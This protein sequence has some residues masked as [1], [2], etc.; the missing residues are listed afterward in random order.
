MICS[1]WD[2][3]Q[4]QRLLEFASSHKF[5][6]AN[7]LY[8]HKL[9]R[10]TT[11]HSPNREVHNQICGRLHPDPKT[12]QSKHQQGADKNLPRGRCRKWSWHGISRTKK[13]QKSDRVRFNIETPK[14]PEVAAT[15]G[16]QFAA[17]NSSNAVLERWTDY[18]QELYK[19]DSNTLNK[20]PGRRNHLV[21][22]TLLNNLLIQYGWPKIRFVTWWCL[23]PVV[24][25]VILSVDGHFLYTLTGNNVQ[26]Y[27][28]FFQTTEKFVW[29]NSSILSIRPLTVTLNLG[30]GTQTF[31]TTLWV[32]VMHHHT[33]FHC[34][35]LS[36]WDDALDDAPVTKQL[37]G[38]RF[39]SA[40]IAVWAFT[41]AIDT[42]D[43]KTTWAEA[44]HQWFQWMGQ[45]AL[46]QGDFIKQLA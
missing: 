40:E 28:M 11:W 24:W 37:R 29:T 33:Q 10:R 20:D 2:K 17:L 35:Q 26:G 9:L 32:V 21:W 44:Q 36:G 16:G 45:C 13:Q 14:H 42:T 41:R 5:N 12:L 22:T 39:E 27:R 34:I 25:P 15:F 31:H 4:R 46:A 19:V 3:Q 6:I 8:P 1:G 18:C 7:T 38:T 23:I 30:I 43:E